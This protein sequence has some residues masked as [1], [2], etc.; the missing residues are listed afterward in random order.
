MHFFIWMNLNYAVVRA[1][2]MDIATL[3][4]ENVMRFPNPEEAAVLNVS[5]NSANIAL[6]HPLLVE[7]AEEMGGKLLI[8]K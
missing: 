6:P 4:G 7:R 3:S 5:T 2:L 8:T 1:G